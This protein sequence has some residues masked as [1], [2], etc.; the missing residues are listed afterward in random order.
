MILRTPAIRGAFA[1]SVANIAVSLALLKKQRVVSH[2]FW[3]VNI[4]SFFAGMAS[5]TANFLTIPYAAED[6]TNGKSCPVFQSKTFVQN[7]E[8]NICHGVPP[9][10]GYIKNVIIQQKRGSYAGS[11]GTD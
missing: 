9:Q 8:K 6:K 2:P 3:V 4:M 11:S 7:A 1:A 5:K 10:T